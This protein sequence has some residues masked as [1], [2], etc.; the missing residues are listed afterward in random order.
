M[1][2][3]CNRRYAAVWDANAV[4][5]SLF[6]RQNIY[7]NYFARFGSSSPLLTVTWVTHRNVT[8]GDHAACGKEI[9]WVSESLRNNTEQNSYG[10]VGSAE[11]KNSF[12]W[13][14]T[15]LPQKYRTQ[16]TPSILNILC[17]AAISTYHNSIS[18]S[19]RGKARGFTLRG[20]GWEKIWIGPL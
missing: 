9:F 10:V 14:A 5:G 1:T 4:T 18:L 16:F 20:W 15:Q 13:T 17:R 3:L 19:Y 2:W 11:H 8:Y 6:R 12:F 7:R